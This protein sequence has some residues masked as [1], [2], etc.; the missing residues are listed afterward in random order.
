[1][2]KGRKALIGTYE[3]RDFVVSKKFAHWISQAS[4]SPEARERLQRAIYFGLG[5]KSPEEYAKEKQD[6][7]IK[8]KEELAEL[9]S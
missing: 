2:G 4:I 3:A 7:I 9:E 8:L 6:K 1:M 5:I